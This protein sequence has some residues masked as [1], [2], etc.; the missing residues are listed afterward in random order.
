MLRLPLLAS[1]LFTAGMAQAQ[2]TL[3]DVCGDCVLEKFATCG[4]FLE[5]AS[6]DRDNR[7]WLVDLTGGRILSVD[8]AGQC[9]VTGN[10]GGQPNGA[11][12]H[13]D[14][15]LFIADKA[16]GILAFDPADKSLTPIVSSYRS[17]LLR[18]VNDLVFDAGGGLYFTEPYGSGT[19]NPTGRLFYLP[20]DGATLRVVADN[21]AFPNGVALSPDGNR[22]Y[23]GEYA[24]KRIT[25]LPSQTSADIFD[26]SFVFS[27][28]QGGIG[29]DGFALDADGNV[30]AAVFQSGSVQITD[31]LGF[32]VGTLRLPADAG[33]F[34]TN[35][36]FK[37]GWLYITE[38]SSGTLW[39]VKVNKG[40]LP[41][42]HQQ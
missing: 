18:G 28:F 17:E 12:F 23:V 35:L 24:N 6:V 42:F 31:R 16:K 15:R 40:G 13:K 22:V 5:G 3:Q 27:H 8:D 25:S 7:L 36:A 9:S 41:Y 1:A 33:T 2:I 19:L 14:G 21:L 10:T 20:A 34:V 29:P 38:A 30:Y 11:K 26:V 32:P 37:D 39:R 4:G